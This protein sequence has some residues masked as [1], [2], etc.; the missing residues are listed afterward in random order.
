M[1][2]DDRTDPASDGP[3]EP[4]A[5]PAARLPWSR[6]EITSIKPLTDV[7]SINYRIGDGIS[8]LS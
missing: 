1:P 2:F 8:N 6:P 5:A 3:S 4:E 7:Q